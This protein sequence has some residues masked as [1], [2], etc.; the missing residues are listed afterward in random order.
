MS[1]QSAHDTCPTGFVLRAGDPFAQADPETIL[2]GCASEQVTETRA[3]ARA[4]SV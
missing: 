2:V 3:I 1:C 4:D